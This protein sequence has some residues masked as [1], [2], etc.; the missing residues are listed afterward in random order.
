MLLYEIPVESGPSMYAREALAPLDKVAVSPQVPP[1]SDG[2]GDPHAWPTPAYKKQPHTRGLP[3]AANLQST[4]YRKAATTT[5]TLEAVRSL[6]RHCQGRPIMIMKRGFIGEGS[7]AVRPAAGLP[8][9]Y[10]LLK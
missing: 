5:P 6:V 10:L 8:V 2:P 9:S 3:H 7:W 1:K 4:W